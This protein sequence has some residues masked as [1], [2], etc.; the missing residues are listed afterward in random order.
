M[1]HGLGRQKPEHQ[2]PLYTPPPSVIGSLPA[3]VDLR[4]RLDAPWR[5][6]SQGPWNTCTA[7]L[8]VVSPSPLMSLPDRGCS[9]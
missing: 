7:R 5:A 8:G 3:S 9:R 1:I 6:V 4:T 2:G